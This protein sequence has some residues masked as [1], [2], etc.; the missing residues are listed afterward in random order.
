MQMLGKK[1][2]IRHVYDNTVA[3][4]LFKDVLIVTDSD[5][6]YKEIKENGGEAIIVKRNTKAEVTGLLRRWQ[7]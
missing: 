2:I 4:G 5:I 3:T 1:P 6:I 7:K